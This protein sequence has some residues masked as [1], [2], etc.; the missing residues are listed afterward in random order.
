MMGK[1]EVICA[2]WVV[3]DQKMLTD[4]TLLSL[5]HSGLSTFI[6]SKFEEKFDLQIQPYVHKCG[7][8]FV[9]YYTREGQVNN[10][11]KLKLRM[12]IK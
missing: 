5:S 3:T 7:S 11:G 10:Y 8:V 12:N 2:R 1:E 4:A 9:C 6:F